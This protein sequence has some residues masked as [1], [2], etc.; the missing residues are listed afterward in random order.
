M[1]KEQLLS[2]LCDRYGIAADYYDI[3]G[4]RH[5][6]TPETQQA[7][8]TA[9]GVQVDDD[10][11]IQQ[12]IAAHDAESWRRLVAP[13]GVCRLPE[14]PS[15]LLSVPHSYAQAVV[16]W[17]LIFESSESHVGQIQLT[18]LE[19]VGQQ[20]IEGVDIV[21]YALPLPLNVPL[22]YHRFKLNISDERVQLSGEMKLVM[23]PDQCYQPPVLA[24]DKRIWGLALQLYA[25]RSRR[26]WGI[27]DF[28][29]LRIALEN[30]ATL[31]AD[32]VGVSPLHALFPDQPERASPYNPSS[33]QFL[34]ILYLDIEAIDDF[35][36]CPEAR[37]WVSEP[38]FQTRLEELRATEHVDY[39]AVAEIKLTVLERLHRHFR[40]H[41]LEQDNERAR[42][43]RRFQ[44]DQGEALAQQ[45]LFE[46]LQ[47]HFHEQDS[48][49]WGWSAWPEQYQDPNSIEVAA[50]AAEHLEQIEFYGYC[51]WQAAL[52]LQAVAW[53]SQELGL[54]IGLYQDLALGVDRGGADS[55][56]N[57]TL[58]ALAISSGA[59]PD[60][61]SPKG[62]I[63]GLPPIIPTQL[64]QAG[65]QPFI[66][67]VR[68]NMQH[69]GALRIDHVMGLMRLYWVVG[70]TAAAGGYVAYPVRDLLSILA[71]ESQRNKCLVIGEDL[72]T[73][74][75]ELRQMLAE[76]GIFSYRLLYFE[77]TSDGSFQA[78]EHYPKK[79]LVAVTTHDLPTLTGY[80]QS[81]DLAIRSELNLFPND[82][83]R[84]QQL[85]DRAQD[86]R[87]LLVA[88]QQQQLLPS[89]VTLDPEQTPA[90]TLE[91][92]CAIYRFL[93][94]SPAQILS[95]QLEDILGQLDQIN[96]PGTINEV[97]NWRRKLS[98][99]VEE[100]L[101]D[102]RLQTLGKALRSR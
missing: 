84:H 46:C 39:Q 51:Q 40:E 98:L 66:D 2:Q 50:F 37:A 75:P 4:Q 93:A 57:K 100:W 60:D 97:P 76:L 55:W 21:R 102:S 23:A 70:E 62:Q 14:K 12:A 33:R 47:A 43:F 94:R 30:A 54:G 56:G 52:Q 45:A 92:V 27:G 19:V 35:A 53:R 82:H 25:I 29:D 26:N 8:L 73:V 87:R 88:L 36:E 11:A 17:Q 96:V 99:A 80:W 18:G 77:K 72:G 49:V 90:M 20:A 67:L 63:W 48:S 31:D 24:D 41:H 7:L 10:T 68:N 44:A 74:P 22:G 58:Y 91:L 28:G 32:L 83:M 42:A 78:P 15:I 79:A 69:A 86:R 65:Y 89:D 16:N 95:V 6:L 3:W 64:Y 9:F 61:F 81:R 59:P 85:S 71:L 38:A 101:T 5:T 13:V 34:N 1:S